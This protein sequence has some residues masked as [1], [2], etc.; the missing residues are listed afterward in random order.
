MDGVN[1]P[2]ID[3]HFVFEGR[4]SM[5]PA[6]LAKSAQHEHACTLWYGLC[7]YMR[8]HGSG[9]GT[10]GST[11]QPIQENNGEVTLPAHQR[12]AFTNA[13][14]EPRRVIQLI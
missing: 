10:S 14:V 5:T 4:R 3:F 1:G 13:L 9:L 6:E 12:R 7:P 11:L 2:F 8:R